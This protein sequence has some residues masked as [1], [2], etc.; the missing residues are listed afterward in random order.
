MS[1]AMASADLRKCVVIGA[2]WGGIKA[3]QRLVA[4]LPADL[5]AAVLIV[6]HIGAHRS[7]LAELLDF[8]GPLRAVWPSEGEEIAARTIYLAPPDRHMVL[9]GTRIRLLASPKENHARPAIDPLFR[10]A[11]ITFRERCIG[12]ILT[13]LLDDGSA[14]LAAVKHC[15]GLALVQDPADAE[16]G[17]MPRNAIA[18]VQVD[19]VAPLHEMGRLIDE[20]ARREAPESTAEPGKEVRMEQELASESG[21]VDTLEALGRP[22]P[23]TCPDCGG[24]LFELTQSPPVRYRCHTGH[25]YT[26]ASLAAFQRQATEDAVWTAVRALGEKLVILQRMLGQTAPPLPQPARDE[27]QSEADQVALAIARLR[28][29]AEH[30]SGPQT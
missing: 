2:S 5:P 14:G 15:G 10:S 1:A 12:V 6:Q 27:L 28:A 11:A 20:L 9:E 23:L 19:R 22:S 25:A 7:Q 29:L 16:Q 8:S 3:L 17:D 21:G 18:N 30:R 24:T 26:L 13:G 4:A